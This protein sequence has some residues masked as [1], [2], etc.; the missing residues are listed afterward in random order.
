MLQNREELNDPQTVTINEARF[1]VPI[2]EVV[3]RQDELLY[4]T[5][6]Y[7]TVLYCTGHQAG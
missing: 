1:S 7:C 4:C 6:L 2:G 3:T 5:L